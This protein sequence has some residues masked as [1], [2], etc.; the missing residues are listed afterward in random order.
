MFPLIA[1]AALA[2]C[3]SVYEAQPG[4][5][6]L[7]NDSY[8][9]II[10][11]DARARSLVLLGEDETEL[12][13]IREGTPL[14]STT[15]ERPFNNELKLATP[16]K[17]RSYQANRIRREGDKLI[18]GFECV[19]YEASVQF[20]LE[21]GYLTFMLDDFIVPEEHGYGRMKMDRPPVAE[22]RLMQLPVAERANF[23]DWLNVMWDDA[24]AVAVAGV[25]PQVLIDHENR[26]GFR[27]MTA[28][29]RPGMMLR[30]GKVA[31]VV[32]RG[33]EAF[34]KSLESV[35]EAFDLPRGVKSRR[36]PLLN[37]S[38]YT[39]W[40]ITPK[41]I[42]RHLE[43]AKRGGFQMMLINVGSIVKS[44]GYAGYELLGDYDWRPE[45]PEGAKSLREMLGKIRAAGIVPG[46]HTLQTHIGVRSRYVTPVLD[47]RLNK[48]RRFT[49]ARPIPETGE[50]GEIFV[51]EPTVDAPMYEGARVLAFGGEA[52]SY[53]G[54]STVPPYRFTGVKRGHYETR[55][56]AH[57][58]GEIGGVLDV[59]EY[60]GRTIYIDQ[61]T[62]LQDE[63]ALKIK[64]ICDCGMLFCYLDGAEGVNPPCNAHVALSQ[65]RVV[66]TFD[67][68]PIF[69]EGAAKSHFSWHLQAGANAFDVFPPEKFKA[70]IVKFPQAEAPAM[71]KDMTRVDFGWWGLY[72]GLQPDMWEFGTSRAAAWDCP[73][74]IQMPLDRVG[75][76][77]R[78]DDCLEVM[79]RWEA[80]RV[81]GWLTAEMKERLKSSTQEHHL[82]LNRRGEY[83]LHEIEMLPTPARAKNARGF[84]F[85]RE[86]KTVLAY[87]HM[88]GAAQIELAMES[89]MTC[90]LDKMRYCETEL[91][92]AEVKAAWAAAVEK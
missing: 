38:I 31:V 59:C 39:S 35:E 89:P 5:I 17:R 28:D 91:S 34:L 47:P 92:V 41:T 32:G 70:M 58:Q 78:L 42:D 79:R 46:L 87:W 29:L 44:A 80:V 90:P 1:W 63:I 4:D 33:R 75:K 21:A 55:A 23:G 54:Y 40:D 49:L 11:A 77:A 27:V 43:Y 8:R 19:P 10:G 52:F 13:D 7:Q 71:A 24:A 67:R 60:G 18:V 74:A 2:G 30:G 12:L 62:S 51:E 6:V 88:T 57:P 53:E 45:Y 25:Q 37:R 64:Q 84:V 48:K 9:L 36:S 65:L 85:E 15:Q 16:N 72:P 81:R 56:A 50:P 22:F 26:P 3:T 66:R 61:N 86:G 83:E 73:A 14:F 68:M 76:V 20:R 82:Y 69:T